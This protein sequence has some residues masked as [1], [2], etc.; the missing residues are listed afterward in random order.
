[1]SMR[2]IVEAGTDAASVML[3]DP[4]ALPEDFDAQMQGEAA[5]VLERMEEQGRACVIEMAG[6]GYYLLHAY[7]NDPLPEE[8]RL[9]ACQVKRIDNLA[10]PTGRLFF[11]GVEYAFRND[12][13]VLRPDPDMPNVIELPAGSYQLTLYRME[14]P[15]RFRKQRLHDCMNPRNWRAYRGM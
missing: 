7:L 8:L 13:S 2:F 5:D 12:N 4:G 15:A 6:D 1:H 10:A 9:H 3:F 11:T 14:Y